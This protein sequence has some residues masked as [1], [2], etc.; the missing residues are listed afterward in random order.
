[1]GNEQ[2]A[3]TE[4]TGNVVTA[5]IKGDY[6]SVGLDATD[7]LQKEI[8]RLEELLRIVEIAK[9][10]LTDDDL[11]HTVIKETVNRTD[12]YPHHLAKV[13]RVSDSTMSRWMNKIAAPHPA[14]KQDIFKRIKAIGKRELTKFQKQLSA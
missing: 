1:M 10:R 12:Q 6:E 9:D 4:N 5:L 14:K 13:L 7:Y 11:F 2:F 3:S 8:K